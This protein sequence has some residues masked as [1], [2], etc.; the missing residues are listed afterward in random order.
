MHESVKVIPIIIMRA[1]E[2]HFREIDV[3]VET[4]IAMVR[5]DSTVKEI[6]RLHL[7]MSAVEMMQATGVKTGPMATAVVQI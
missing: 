3:A 5:M 4:P 1:L 2:E 7:R 6:D